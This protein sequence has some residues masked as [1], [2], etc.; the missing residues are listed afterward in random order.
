MLSISC[1]V[2]IHSYFPL[3]DPSHFIQ[4]LLHPFLIRVL[5]SI[6]LQSGM[7][8]KSSLHTGLLETMQAILAVGM[9]RDVE[10]HYLRP[11]TPH[12]SDPEKIICEM[13]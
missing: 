5:R 2:W 10:S 1:S 8:S 12:L 6:S 4:L 9:V 7:L 11:V 13:N 3:A